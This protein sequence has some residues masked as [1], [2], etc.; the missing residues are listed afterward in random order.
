MKLKDFMEAIAGSNLSFP[1]WI[2]QEG[3]TLDW[4]GPIKLRMKHKSG[5]VYVHNFNL[6][7]FVEV[8]LLLVEPD[9]K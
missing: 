6:Q 7:D 9:P 2:S 3:K 5:N 8:E 1:E 4:E